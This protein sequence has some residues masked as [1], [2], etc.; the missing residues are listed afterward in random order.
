[1]SELLC[2]DIIQVTDETH[3]WYPCLLIV[4]EVRTWG[5]QAYLVIPDNT[6]GPNGTAYIRIEKGA[7]ECVGAAVVLAL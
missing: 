2:G 4:Q 5:V 6:D 1:V 7:Y 3:H